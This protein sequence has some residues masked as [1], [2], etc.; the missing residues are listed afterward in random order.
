[1]KRFS[2]IIPFAIALLLSA[3]AAAQVAPL[4][5]NPAIPPVRPI[6]AHQGMVVAQEARAA[7][8]GVQILDRGGNAVD[9]A[10]AVGFAL[11]V[12]YPRAGNIGG[13]GFMVIHLASGNRD[14]AI[15]YRE[16]A[17]AAATADHVPR[18]AGQ[19]RSEQVARL[20]PCRRRARHR[21]RPRAGAP[22]I[23]LGE[24]FTSRPHGA[25]NQSGTKRFSSAG[26]LGG[27]IATRTRAAGALAGVEV[28]LFPWRRHAGRRRPAHPV[29]SCR[30][31]GTNCTGRS[32][33]LLSRPHRRA[34]RRR[35]APSRRHHDQGRSRQLPR[36]RARSGARQLS[37]QHHRLHAAALLRRRGADRDAQYSRRLRP[38]QAR[39]RRT[40]VSLY[41]RGDEA[42]LCRPRR[43]YGRSRRGEDADRRP[44]VEKICRS[45]T[46]RHQR[47]GNAGR[48]HPSR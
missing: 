21:G 19:P 8:I 34:D 6:L 24:V 27:F 22:E 29:R 33:S 48:R 36:G 14:V 43:L 41:D 18:R 39:A 26:R 2:G 3:L 20:R 46:R 11:A 4:T 13:G 1:M 38:R 10:V 31:A 15:D 25:R 5:P 45:F 37:R 23:R 32:E 30:H 42:R 47:Q 7:R 17:P 28:D 35:G 44:A 9:A 16:T 12:T 40:I